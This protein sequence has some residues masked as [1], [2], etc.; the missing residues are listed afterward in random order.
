MEGG[1]LLISVFN[2]NLKVETISYIHLFRSL[3]AQFFEQCWPHSQMIGNQ[4]W[5]SF[6]LLLQKWRGYFFPS[7]PQGVDEYE[8]LCW[9]LL[10]NELILLS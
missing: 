2:W 8:K 1:G 6:P 7:C 3:V 10:N 5:V 9:L 4:M